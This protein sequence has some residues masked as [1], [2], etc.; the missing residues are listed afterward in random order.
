MI[1][2]EKGRGFT[3]IELLVAAA[4]G[5]IFLSA[6]ATIIIQFI[7][8]ER[9]ETGR[10]EVQAEI[11]QVMDFITADLREAVYVY[12]DADDNDTPDLLERLYYP[13][14]PNPN[15]ILQIANSIPVLAFWKQEDRTQLPDACFVASNREREFRA[16]IAQLDPNPLP[17]TVATTVNVVTNPNTNPPTTE[18]RIQVQSGTYF[19]LVTYYLRRNIPQDGTLWEGS[20]RIIRSV[21]RPVNSDCDARRDYFRVDPDPSDFLNW[22]NYAGAPAQAAP[23][24]DQVSPDV[25]ATNIFW[26]GENAPACPQGFDFGGG[27]PLNLPLEPA[28]TDLGPLPDVNFPDAGFYTCVQRMGSRQFPQSIFISLTGI[29]MDRANPGLFRRYEQDRSILEEDQVAR[30]LHTL[31]SQAL[32]RAVFGRS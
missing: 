12:N 29:S 26:A 15:R 7:Q 1:R 5:L 27:L 22:P 24:F 16:A 9:E 2:K 21:L 13:N 11:S 25:L 14:T 20:A 23:V 31:E 10:S 6:T 3:L 4:I 18:R 28:S 30:Y 8:I 19:S 17:R 32:A